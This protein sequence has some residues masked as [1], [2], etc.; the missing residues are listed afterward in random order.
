MASKNWIELLD[1]EGVRRGC[2]TPVYREKLQKMIIY[3]TSFNDLKDFTPNQITLLKQLGFRAIKKR[4]DAGHQMLATDIFDNSSNGVQSTR[5]AKEHLAILKQ[6]YPG[7][8]V[9]VPMD[10]VEFNSFDYGSPVVANQN[11]SDNEI[12]EAKTND[13]FR[14]GLNQHGQT[15]YSGN[16][17]QRYYEGESGGLKATT[18]MSDAEKLVLHNVK[19]DD[20][21]HMLDGMIQEFKASPDFDITDRQRYIDALIGKDDPSIDEGDLSLNTARAERLVDQALNCAPYKALIGRNYTDYKD[22]ESVE[23]LWERIPGRQATGFHPSVAAGAFQ[24]LTAKS[25]PDEVSL[26][27]GNETTGHALAATHGMGFK[28]LKANTLE[29]DSIDGEILA[30]NE[31]TIT[32]IDTTEQSIE[33][34]SANAIML[35]HDQTISF[36]NPIHRDEFGYQYA[37][38]I[39]TVNTLKGLTDDGLALV[40]IPS[41]DVNRDREFVNH[42]N[43]LF[44]VESV[45]F[46]DKSG[47]YKANDQLLISISSKRYV[48]DTD[49]TFNERFSNFT[50][51]QE[52]FDWLR[53]KGE[54]V[55]AVQQV[56]DE[57]LDFINDIDRDSLSAV[58]NTISSRNKTE[59]VNPMQVAYSPLSRP[60]NNDENTICIPRSL[61]RAMNIA[62]ARTIRRLQKAGFTGG[63]AVLDFLADRLQYDKSFLMDDTKLG[64]HQLDKAAL[65]ILLY[66]QE[67]RSLIDGS[68]TGTGKT[69]MMALMAR[70]N[71]LN[72]IPIYLS[73][74]NDGI[75]QKFVNEMI[76]LDSYHL[77]SPFVLNHNVRIYDQMGNSITRGANETNNKL[78]EN[79]DI[80][81]ANIIFAT[82]GQTN[83][84]MPPRRKME[85]LDDYNERL[86]KTKTAMIHK[87]MEV[88]RPYIIL[89]ES[90]ASAG[91]SNSF[92]AAKEL[93]KRSR[94]ILPLSGT[95]IPSIHAINLYQPAFPTEM[96]TR[97]LHE[98]LI[99]GG[100]PMSEAIITALA[101][102]GAYYRVDLPDEKHFRLV[103]PKPEQVEFN[104]HSAEGLAGF[105]DHYTTITGEVQGA[106]ST[107]VSNELSEEEDTNTKDKTPHELGFDSMHFGSKVARI[108]SSTILLH[109]AMAAADQIEAHINDNR[110]VIYTMQHTGESQLTRSIEHYGQTG[111]RVHIPTMRDMC[112]SLLDSIHLVDRRV[113]K[114]IIQVDVRDGMSDIERDEFDRLLQE[115][116]NYVTNHIPEIPFS[117]M[118]TIRA[119]LERRGITSTE[120][121]ARKMQLDDINLEDNTAKLLPRKNDT[122]QSIKDFHDGK[123]DVIFMSSAGATGY[124]MHARKDTPDN[125]LVS[126]I[127]GELD[128]F[129]VTVIQ[130]AGRVDRLGQVGKPLYEIANPGLPAV[131][132]MIENSIKKIAFV[133]SA[134]T[135]NAKNEMIKSPHD[136]E[137]CILSEPGMKAVVQYL[138]YNPDLASRLYME[139]E[140]EPYIGDRDATIT[141]N[142]QV[143][144]SNKFLSR[145]MMLP[146]QKALE[147]INDVSAE[148]DNILKEQRAIGIDNSGGVRFLDI[149]GTITNKSVVQAAP[150][151]DKKDDPLLGDVVAYTVEYKVDI[152]PMS[153]DDVIAL[154]E[155]GNERINNDRYF[156]GRGLNK[157]SDVIKANYH[158]IMESAL[159]KAARNRVARVSNPAERNKAIDSEVF[160]SLNA[161]NVQD[162]MSTILN[163]NYE[164]LTWVIENMERMGP[165]GVISYTPNNS[166]HS[167]DGVI[168]GINRPRPG[169]EHNIS[170]W[171]LNVALPGQSEPQ[172]VS[173]IDV[174]RSVSGQSFDIETFSDSHLLALEFDSQLASSQ[175][176]ELNVISGNL[177]KAALMLQRLSG[178]MS[179]NF[180][181]DQGNVR[182]GFQL[183]E[184]ISLRDL[185]GLEQP[186]P[187]IEVAAAY[188]RDN[189]GHEINT[190]P[191]AISNR[192]ANI[193]RS[194]DSTFTLRVP[195]NRPKGGIYHYETMSYTNPISGE[196]EHKTPIEHITGKKWKEKKAYTFI[197]IPD[198]KLEAVLEE[199]ERVIAGD[200]DQKLFG[201]KNSNEWLNRYFDHQQREQLS[202]I[203]T[204]AMQDADFDPND[205]YQPAANMR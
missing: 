60:F 56:A 162:G 122:T 77:M 195:R 148:A 116:Q 161:K 80:P 28:T 123:A 97:E 64:P 61:Q 121:S 86:S 157:A 196:V 88:H 172:N 181:D 182:R 119:D 70:Y 62:Q 125:R 81:D 96:N 98:A 183:P 10:N 205:N 163:H 171:G 65:A 22:I 118:D 18:R 113:G 44:T 99:K 13:L 39:D 76:L 54:Q 191:T 67:G 178:V 79:K 74:H 117:P 167:V 66:E 203:P 194:T 192:H 89:D 16:G 101:E 3:L 73:G 128:N 92:E 68:G 185:K 108:T 26:L 19:P 53:I 20:E 55:R 52:C 110:K 140:I 24:F 7:L 180:T 46:L 150:N 35:S 2:L 84:S 177:P 111:D 5:F 160:R 102:D 45:A 175:N 143:N 149:K 131:T 134:T 57:R 127:Y 9:N 146:P 71:L 25:K 153:T 41:V 132:R 14:I 154:I 100:L 168:V 198:N 164:A 188:L 189:V 47:F 187:S 58:A 190:H 12:V 112:L 85:S 36:A 173:L 124:D 103:E 50:A 72:D 141:Y 31:T 1:E 95:S 6:V 169:Q 32:S 145:L 78:M 170:Q 11:A 30:S 156:E 202:A 199:V 165:G 155:V 49:L 151:A 82:V 129:A 197:D 104:I 43:S 115:A 23:Q 59:I 130:F 193:L 139:K 109:N 34:G 40:Q 137:A 4:T 142:S 69:R 159:P 174:Y 37:H 114:Q 42:L 38:E 51:P 147:V 126:M 8:R 176:N 201:S 21:I 184:K 15:I 158:S 27:V 179:I 87:W 107:I 204:A 90:H 200:P 75:F 133:S 83:R 138:T 105:F 17:G 106:I 33:G 152:K 63:D 186:M 93:I 136:G 29:K 166:I 48:Q 94:G 120:I 91:E 144:I 135:A